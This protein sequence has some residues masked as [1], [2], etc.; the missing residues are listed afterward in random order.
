[1]TIHERLALYPVLEPYRSGIL[2]VGDGHSVYFEECGNPEGEPAL[3]VHGGPGGGSNPTMQAGQAYAVEQIV[4]VHVS[5]SAA[6]PRC[7]AVAEPL[8]AVPAAMT[9][10]PSPIRKADSTLSAMRVLC[11][12]RTASRSTTTSIL[13]RW[14]RARRR[15]R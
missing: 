13:C 12:G 4:S 2:D 3:L 9:K 14:W 5:V 1:M 10:F 6:G 8:G 15:L 11:S 7:V